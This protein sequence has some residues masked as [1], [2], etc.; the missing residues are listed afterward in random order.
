MCPRQ[1][2]LLF[3]SYAIPA[4]LIF[5]FKARTSTKLKKSC[6]NLK[7]FKQNNGL[8]KQQLN[9]WKAV[10]ITASFF[11][12]FFLNNRGMV[13]AW[14]KIKNRRQ[15]LVPT[16]LNSQKVTTPNNAI[17]LH[18]LSAFL[19][20]WLRERNS[21]MVTFSQIVIVK[22]NQSLNSFFYCWHLKKC[23]LVISS[24]TK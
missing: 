24:E 16:F 4:V 8:S 10:K 5:L 3:T 20:S 18:S 23:H 21:Q 9:S 19:N 2:N 17:H 22:I 13:T 7:S 6:I 12:Y 15:T 1:P 11:N 14:K